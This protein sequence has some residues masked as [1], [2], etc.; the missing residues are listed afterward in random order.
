M[1]P[2]LVYFLVGGGLLLIVLL[3]IGVV[4]SSSSER[5]LMEQRL[6]DYLDESAK[7]VAEQEAEKIGEVFGSCYIDED[8]RPGCH[9]KNYR[10]QR[11]R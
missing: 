8:K 1:S 4:V 5:K 9:G 6:G 2:I 7:S 11:E 3:V 10:S